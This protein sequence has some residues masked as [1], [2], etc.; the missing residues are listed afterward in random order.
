MSDLAGRGG[1]DLV[2]K[3]LGILPVVSAVDPESAEVLS[4]GNGGSS[5]L[6]PL[7]RQSLVPPVLFSDELRE[8]DY[9]AYQDLMGGYDAETR[10]A[11]LRLDLRHLPKLVENELMTHA[12]AKDYRTSGAR[13]VDSGF[14]A[15][16][17]VSYVTAPRPSS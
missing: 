11:V 10:A 9:C 5:R 1:L 15:Y 14:D 7:G 16:D 2:L 12:E 8:P 3:C 17:F 6:P 4:A 13:M